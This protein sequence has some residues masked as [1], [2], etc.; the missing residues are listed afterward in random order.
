ID[1]RVL[2]RDSLLEDL[3]AFDQGS[4]PV[5]V[6]VID[7]DA[8]GINAISKRLK[9]HRNVSSVHLIAFQDLRGTHLGQADLNPESVPALTPTFSLWRQSLAADANVLLYGWWD[10]T[11]SAPL[12]LAEQ[13]LLWSDPGFEET[14]VLPSA[15][16]SQSADY[17]LLDD[18]AS[19]AA[20][21][22]EHELEQLLGV[23]A[24]LATGWLDHD[25]LSAAG[26]LW[27]EAVQQAELDEWNQLPT[28][29]FI[30]EV[31]LAEAAASGHRE[32]V[33]IDSQL[34]D[35][36]QLVSA[37]SGADSQLY[38]V[39]VLDSTADGLQFISNYLANSGETFSAIHL[40]THGFAGGLQL[41]S[42]TLTSSSLDLYANQLAAW[43]LNLTADA[44]LL[45]YGCYIADGSTGQQFVSDLAG[46]I[47]RDIAASTDA[48]GAG[49]L[50]G[51]WELEYQVGKI[52]QTTPLIRNLDQAWQ[53]LL[54]T[55]TVRDDFSL[56]VYTNNDGTNNWTAGWSETDSG[57]AGANSGHFLITGGQL[58]LQP[59]NTAN[60]LSRQANLSGAHAA[61]LTFSFDSTLDDNASNSTITLEASS[62]GSTWTALDTFTRTTNTAAGN[63]SYDLT[64]YISST[65][66]VRFTVTTANAGAFYLYVDNF[67]I[68]YDINTA[69]TAVAD[70]A[71]AVEAGGVSNGTAGTNPNGNVLTNDTDADSGDTKT[72]TGVAAGV[73]GSASGN[74][75]SSVTG[76]YG[77]I[78]IA[79]NGAYTYTVDNSNATV[80]A[81]RT[82]G[83][84]LT[85]TFTYTMR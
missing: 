77:T 16:E 38:T 19:S 58:R 70:S 73:V 79:A 66:S 43:Q 53:H 59:G 48:T 82:S 1:A 61:T 37:W 68:S 78:N 32:L 39:V 11:G 40:L 41:G 2:T 17:H 15:I 74:V 28:A 18:A 8:N 23:R 84:T 7:A 56:A 20:Q 4:N 9:T 30:P 33:F 34:P 13:T 12:Q 75:G 31:S 29:Q 27:S 14:F 45:L 5:E 60:L 22:L 62:N 85:D 63:K 76:T 51:D 42:T 52:A 80:Q 47:H 72:V 64:S 83:N 10:S 46:I 81:L 54:L 26:N 65:T 6:M 3:S 24:E 36:A 49:L 67:Q 35:L 55:Y 57:G 44:D 69:P 71:T 21:T 25:P 50:G